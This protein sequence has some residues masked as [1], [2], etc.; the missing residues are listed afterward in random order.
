MSND[1]SDSPPGVEGLYA[2][3]T[4][5]WPTSRFVSIHESEFEFEDLGICV[6]SNDISGL[7]LGVEHLCTRSTTVQPSSRFV[8]LYAQSS[9]NLST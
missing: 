5:I 2:N 4:T 7:P 3:S 8:L 9:S 1:I 6:V